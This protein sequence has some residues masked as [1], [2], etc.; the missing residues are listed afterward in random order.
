MN[1]IDEDESAADAYL[2]ELNKIG[3][4][5]NRDNPMDV[6]TKIVG[7]GGEAHKVYKAGEDHL[8]VNGDPYAGFAKGPDDIPL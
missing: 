2:S 4:Q 8:V 7:K 1:Q 5:C 6:N 3:I